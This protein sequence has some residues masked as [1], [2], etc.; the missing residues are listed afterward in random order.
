MPYPRAQRFQPNPFQKQLLEAC[1]S[2]ELTAAETAVRTGKTGASAFYHRTQAKHNPGVLGLWVCISYSW[3]KRIAHQVCL[4]LFG[5][6]AKWN[7]STYSWTWPNGARVMVLSYEYI[8][9]WEGATAGWGSIDE[10]QEIGRDAYDALLLR[11][12]DAR[13]KYPHIL[14]TGLPVYG[15]WVEELVR[16]SKDVA[17]FEEIETSVN[18]AH[19]HPTY[20]KRLEN[21]LSKDEY[22]RR[23]RGRKPLPKGRVFSDFVPDIYDPSVPGQRGNLIDW[24]IRPELETYAGVDFGRHA[25]VIVAQRDHTRDIDVIVKEFH[26]R[27]IGTRAMA[28]M[29]QGVLVPRRKMAAGDTRLPVDKWY[30]DPAGNSW[31]SADAARDIEE[32]Q[33]ELGAQMEYTFASDLRRIR[34]GIGIVN[35]RFCSVGGQR[36]LLIDKTLWHA[37]LRSDGVSLTKSILESRYPEDKAGR[38]VSDEPLRS[39]VADDIS[40]IRDALRYSQVNRY[41]SLF[42]YNGT[43]GVR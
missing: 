30:C 14:V 13:A 42:G 4:E 37:G 19:V 8:E 15:S 34:N 24:Q 43:V 41:G 3:Y 7:G 29:L 31:Q 18:A 33:L 25:G 40:H 23:A 28:R 20:L 22:E 36:R 2:H 12:S 26:P 11:I 17:Y 10:C 27:D 35:G 6:E 5:H 21:T 39:G 1:F 38:A 9:S 32:M 16:G